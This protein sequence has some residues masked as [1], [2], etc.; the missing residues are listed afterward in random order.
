VTGVVGGYFL[1][2]W[3]DAR[4]HWQFATIL[5]LLLGIAGSFY[6][7]VKMLEQVNQN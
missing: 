1:G 7:V 5:C 6:L 4:L 2:S 3:L